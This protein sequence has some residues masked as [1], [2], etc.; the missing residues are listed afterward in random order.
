M[1]NYNYEL[2]GNAIVVQAA[3]DYR[4]ALRTQH[5]NPN[6]EK[7]NKEVIKIEKFFHS[8]YF[9]LLTD[10]NGPELAERIKRELIADNWVIKR[11]YLKV[12]D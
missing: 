1:C 7:N 4:V 12:G 8:E 3:R 6:D 5:L 2:L 10:L 9:K 11:E